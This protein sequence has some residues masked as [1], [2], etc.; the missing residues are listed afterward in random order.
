MLK[1]TSVELDLITD[2]DMY[3]MVEKGMC[4]GISSINHRFSIANNPRM[5]N[6]DP[7]C[8]TRTLTY[9]DANALYSWA[10]CQML[11]LR[12]FEWISPDEIDVLNIT[13]DNIFGYILEVDL[14]YPQELH[15][16][17]DLYPLAPEHLEISNDMLSPFQKEN[18]PQI[19]GSI[20]K[21][22]PNLFDKEKYI[23]EIFS[24]IYLLE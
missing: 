16:K 5:K 23:V 19:R 18:F 10:M 11:P 24:C 2:I 1:Y 3:Q 12:K 14:E 9:Q 21:L 20:R 13:S 22:V 17:H 8:R 7:T 6:Y 15:D 4:G